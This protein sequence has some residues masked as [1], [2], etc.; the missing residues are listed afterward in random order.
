MSGD[1]RIRRPYLRTQGDDEPGERGRTGRAGGRKSSGRG[2]SRPR[3]V[4][5]PRVDA[6]ST[7]WRSGLS[8]RWQEAR[9]ARA[10]RAQLRATVRRRRAREREDLRAAGRLD[11]SGDLAGGQQRAGQGR[12]ATA[13]TR[14]SIGSLFHDLHLGR[15]LIIGLAVVIAVTIGLVFSPWLSVQH[16]E[17]RGTQRA[18][19][20]ELSDALSDQVGR[21]I[22]GLS[23]AQIERELQ[24]FS[25]VESYSIRAELPGTLIVTVTERAPIGVFKKGDSYL[26]VDAA[27]VV[28]QSADQPEEGYPTLQVAS[29]DPQSPAFSSVAAVLRSLDGDLLAQVATAQASTQDDVQL[30]LRSGTTVVWGDGSETELKARVLRALVGDRPDAKHIDVSSPSLPVAS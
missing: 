11:R 29:T 28:V 9:T 18:S 20:A 26:L 12:A 10:A 23:G 24:Q 7:D 19:A 17:V 13:A 8:A 15:F 30:T 4:G 5:T 25:A 22:I 27:G 3:E 1:D 2:T 21:P 16:I 6:E 14:A